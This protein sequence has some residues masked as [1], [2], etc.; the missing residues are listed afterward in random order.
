MSELEKMPPAA[1]MRYEDEDSD[2]VARV[3][4]RIEYADGRIR[5][6]EA[7]EPQAF[8]MNDPADPAAMTLQPMRMAVQS[9]GSPVV[10][11]MAAVPS[12]RLSFRAHPRHNM[13][14]R[15]ER[16]AAPAQSAS[17]DSRAERP[18]LQAHSEPQPEPQE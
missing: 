16:T 8:D 3:L 14:I 2:V 15:T 6:Y 12:L 10:S 7:A 5:E 17:D 13:H 11:M 18:I 9:G 4:V 1:D